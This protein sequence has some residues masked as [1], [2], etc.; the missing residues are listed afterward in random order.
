M[1]KEVMMALSTR[2][3]GFMQILLGELPDTFI[4]ENAKMANTTYNDELPIC[5]CTRFTNK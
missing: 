4:F 5:R 2:R 1:L 3:G